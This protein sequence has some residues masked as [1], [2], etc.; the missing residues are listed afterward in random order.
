MILR[1]RAATVGR[2]SVQAPVYAARWRAHLALAPFAS[3]LLL[4]STLLPVPVSAAEEKAKVAATAFVAGE[5]FAMPPFIARGAGAFQLLLHSL[6]DLSRIK[7][8]QQGEQAFLVERSQCFPVRHFQQ[9]MEVIGHEAVGHDP[10]PGESL[11]IPENLAEDFLIP[12]LEDLA[13]VHDP[14]HHVVKGSSGSEEAGGAH[15]G[16]KWLNENRQGKRQTACNPR[17]VGRFRAKSSAR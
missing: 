17:K 10:N 11:L 6:D 7:Q 16:L 4:A 14:G 15:S 2:A 1:L 3:L 5:D 12:G 8:G 9:E 13:P